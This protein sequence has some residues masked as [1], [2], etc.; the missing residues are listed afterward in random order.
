MS[1]YWTAAGLIYIYAP[2]RHL[3]TKETYNKVRNI[4]LEEINNPEGKKVNT[5]DCGKMTREPLASID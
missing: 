1:N 3:L 4:T 5:L 2:S